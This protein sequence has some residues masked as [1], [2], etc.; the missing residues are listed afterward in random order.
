MPQ[1]ARI[2]IEM[3]FSAE[4]IR[5]PKAVDARLQTLLDRQDRG[6]RLSVGERK[7]AEGLVE[8]AEMLSLMRLRSERVDNT[9]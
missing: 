9:R 3:P 5:L 4:K 2:K 6:E 1:N 7:E 8:L